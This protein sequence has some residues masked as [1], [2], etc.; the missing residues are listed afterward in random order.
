MTITVNGAPRETDAAM[1]LAVLITELTGSS[2]GSA[3]VVDGDVIPRSQW[4]T[5]ALR[6]GQSVEL[7]TAVQGG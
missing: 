2:R 1:T 5:F 4:S 3:A 6:D 7:I